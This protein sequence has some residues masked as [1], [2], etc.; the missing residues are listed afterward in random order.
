MLEGNDVGKRKQKSAWFMDSEIE[1]LSEKYFVEIS[2]TLDHAEWNEFLA[3]IGDMGHH[4][5]TTCWA[6]VQHPMDWR[7]VR[8]VVR[9]EGRITGG[10]QILIQPKRVLGSIV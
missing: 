2:E 7:S 10:A 4:E 5:Q 9:R 6:A 3:G 1:T 8:S